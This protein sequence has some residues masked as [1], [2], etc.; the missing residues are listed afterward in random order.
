M[1]HVDFDPI[2]AMIELFACSFPGFH[3]T[4]DDLR[5]LGHL[6]F[7][8][9]ALEHVTRRR[10]NGARGDKKSRAGYIA[11]INSL[12]YAYITVSG[13]FRFDVAQGREALLERPARRHPCAQSA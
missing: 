7:G 4:I 8:G 10:G 5:T 12:L 11:Q 3:R 2:G 6:E 1:S 9:I 13:T